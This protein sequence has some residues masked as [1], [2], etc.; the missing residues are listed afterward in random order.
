MKKLILLGLTVIFFI[1]CQNKA[2]ER[3]TT[4][5][6][7]IDV[8]KT[9]IKDYQ[10]GN[11]ES[12]M[13]HYADTAKIYHNTWKNSVT[14]GENATFLK[15]ILA[16]MSSYHFDDVED[17][18]FYEMVIDNEE[19]TIVHFWGNY[20]G[21]LAANNREIEF[22]VHLSLMFVDNKI[23]VEWGFY[24]LA[25]IMEALN[26]IEAAKMDDETE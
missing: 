21:T 12:W 20:K 23:A 8:V 9:L 13:T 26:E 11:W 15:D 5:S 3:Y 6:P 7:E 10:D 25:E 14:P 2:T 18:I 22:P 4:T 16:N 17:E 1:A 19:N 24:N